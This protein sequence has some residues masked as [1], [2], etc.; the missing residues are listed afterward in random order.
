MLTQA[1]HATS[2]RNSLYGSILKSTAIYSVAIVAQRLAGILLLPV[3]T[4]FLSPRDY[5]TMELLD[6]SI[7]LFGLFLG[8]NLSNAVSYFYFQNEAEEHRRKLF[9]T[10]MIG[11]TVV[12]AIASAL[13]LSTS[14][15]LS[16]LVF[17]LPGNA[18]Y[19][20][21]MFLAFAVS[22]PTEAG[23][24]WLRAQ[25]RSTMFVAT[26]V[27]R[28]AMAIV[29]NV[30][31]LVVWRL[32]ITGVLLS[33][34]AVT[35]VMLMILY[36]LCLPKGSVAVDRRL[37][38]ETAR[39]SAPLGITG[40]AMFVINFGDRFFLQRYVGLNSLGIYSLAYKAGMLMSYI[41]SAFG[42]YWSSQCY[43][44][45]GGN[46]GSAVYAR[47]FTY[48]M[49][50]MTTS[51]LVLTLF[52]SPAVAL[53]AAPAFA[54]ADKLIP[55]IAFAYLLRAVGDYFRTIFY[56]SKR[57]GLDASV[58]AISAVFCLAGYGF[59]IPRF[60]LWGAVAATWLGFVCMLALAFVLGRRLWPFRLEGGRLLQL[61]AG[62]ALSLF[63]FETVHPHRPL[64][65]FV[66]AMCCVLLYVATLA[67]LGFFSDGEREALRDF[68][69]KLGRQETIPVGAGSHE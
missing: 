8:L 23:F 49:T 27:L 61:A 22:L 42:S 43:G 6:L 60:G 14:T 30:A 55:W 45:L 34:L 25:N 65:A 32:G 38:W 39:Y 41:Y 53:I 69:R 56:V 2:R 4:R 24:A 5:G 47:V 13:G 36:A 46:S 21:L 66:T 7:S 44:L 1:P 58:Y 54:T 35:T 19:F 3:Y 59:L 33:N 40:I 67:A 57:T 31:L 12:G 63:V 9:H 17:Q 10:V 68:V 18:A 28:L 11:A 48:V 62:C 20:R 52:A 50:A 29:L 15:A 51:A 26:S 37:L 64:W 16:R